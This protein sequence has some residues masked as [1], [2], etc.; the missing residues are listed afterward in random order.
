MNVINDTGDSLQSCA[1][2]YTYACS[3]FFRYCW[4]QRRRSAR[5]PAM[6]VRAQ[7]AASLIRISLAME[8][9]MRV[10][11]VS[12]TVAVIND[13][14]NAGTDPFAIPGAIVEYT[15][16][17][18]NPDTVAI[19]TDGVTL[20]D[21]IPENTVFVNDPID[22]GL[23]VALDDGAATSGLTLAAANIRFSDDDGVT[24]DYAPAAGPDI[25]I[26]AIRIIPSGQLSPAGIASFRFR[27]LIQ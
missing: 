24:Y 1:G 4:L 26:D 19:D 13:P 7:A 15:I 27:V 9:R 5:V 25:E 6:T 8:M 21:L 23:P 12:V 16:S 14:V 22:A 17:V 10:Q 11:P 18:R 2:R 20:T 3:Q